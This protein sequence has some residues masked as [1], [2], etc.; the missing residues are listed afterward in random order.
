M[1][2]SIIRFSQQKTIKSIDYSKIDKSIDIPKSANDFFINVLKKEE[3]DVFKTSSIIKLDK[4]NESFSQYYRGILVDGAGYAFHYDNEGIMYYAHGNYEHIS[5]L[6]IAPR[7]SGKDAM[8][9]FA[10][11]KG[12]D[13]KKVSNYSSELIIKVLMEKNKRIPHLSFKVFL[14]INHPKNTEYGY[15]DAHTGEIICTESFVFHLT[16]NAL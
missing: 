16:N 10:Q 4:N 2:K 9:L 5:N 12:F 6:D 14:N 11:Y 1:S 7:I 3:N 8:E 15:V 13:I